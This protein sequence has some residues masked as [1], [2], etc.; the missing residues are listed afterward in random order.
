MRSYL[1]FLTKLLGIFPLLVFLN[2]CRESFSIETGVID[3]FSLAW[4]QNQDP[5]LLFKYGYLSGT[6]NNAISETRYYQLNVREPEAP[7]L[8]EIDQNTMQSQTPPSNLLGRDLLVK[9]L[10]KLRPLP[11]DK[12]SLIKNNNV[13]ACSLHPSKQWL[14]VAHKQKPSTPEMP[15][16]IYSLYQIEDHSYRNLKG[17]ASLTRSNDPRREVVLSW[18]GFNN[19]ILV[20]YEEK[21][22]VYHA[23]SQID[24]NTAELKPLTVFK[25]YAQRENEEKRWEA[26]FVPLSRHFRPLQ[27]SETDV[28]VLGWESADKVFFLEKKANDRAISLISYDFQTQTETQVAK[29]EREQSYYDYLETREQISLPQDKVVYLIRKA[30]EGTDELWL[31]NFKGTERTMILNRIRDLPVGL[32]EFVNIKRIIYPEFRPKIIQDD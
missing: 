29:M 2:G 9:D 16:T 3:P 8:T 17:L 23:R 30:K 14:L 21:D 15:E 28:K 25:S 32:S 18:T 20:E 31:S 27:D 26:S 4:A 19:D 6:P 24:L 7:V 22:R 1:F 11:N 13:V 5:H 10:E 12:I